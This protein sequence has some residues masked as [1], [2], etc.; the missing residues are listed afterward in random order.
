MYVY[1]HDRVERW[2]KLFSGMRAF[3][4]IRPASRKWG[5]ASTGGS[6]NIAVTVWYFAS[7]KARQKSILDEYL[8]HII[9]TSD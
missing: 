3:R 5:P 2:Q 1:F 9:P 8:E 7:L 6:E 4:K